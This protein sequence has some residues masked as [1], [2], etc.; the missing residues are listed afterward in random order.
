MGAKHGAE[1]NRKTWKEDREAEAAELGYRASPIALSLV[2]VRAA[3][4]SEPGRAS[5]RC[6]RSLSKKNERSG[7]CLIL[8]RQGLKRELI[9]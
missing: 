9:R 5:S 2:A 6:R 7:D 4:R 3:S 1:R 8:R